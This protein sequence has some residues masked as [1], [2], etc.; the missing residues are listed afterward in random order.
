MA[1]DTS[2]TLGINRSTFSLGRSL[3]RLSALGLILVAA[4]AGA[5]AQDCNNNGIDD[6]CDLDCGSPGGGCDVP[7]C[8]LA[9][10]CDGN[11]VPDSCDLADFADGCSFTEVLDSNG[12]TASDATFTGPPDDVYFGLGGQQVTYRFDCGFIYDGPGGDLN[13]YEVDFGSAEFGAV[14]VLVS[15]DG[16]NFTSIR[17]SAHAAAVIPGDELHGSTNFARSYDIG[18]AGLSTVRYVRLDGNG[19]GPSGTS[20]GFD[21]DA[22]GV[23]HRLGLDCDSSGTLDSCEPL[24]DCDADGAPDACTVSLGAALD[25][26]TNGIPDQCDAGGTSNDCDG[27][28]VPDEC[29]ADCDL[30]GTPD[31]CDTAGGV[32]DCNANIRPDSCDLASAGPGYAE[33]SPEFQPYGGN[34][35]QSWT[36]P[37]AFAANG[38]VTL[39]VRALSDL[40]ATTEYVEIELNGV[41]LGRLFEGGGNNCSESVANLIIDADTFNS[42]VAGGD[43]V[44]QFTSPSAVNRG[45]CGSSRIQADLSYEAIVDCNSNG[46]VDGCDIAAGADDVNLNGLPDECEPDCNGNGTPDDYDVSQGISPDCNGNGLPDSCD[47][48]AATSDDCDLDGTPDECQPDCNGNGVADVCDISGGTSDDCDGNSVPDSCELDAQ[49][50]ACDFGSIVIENSTGGDDAAFLGAP[51]GDFWGIG[52]QI[53]T[54]E[55]TCGW[56]VDGPGADLTLY[57][58]SSGGQEFDQVQLLVSDDGVNYVDISG[59]ARAGQRIPGDQA[60]GGIAFRRSYDLAGSGLD[61]VRFVRINGSGSGSGGSSS[62]FDLDAVGAIHLLRGDCDGSGTLDVCE[63]LAD[64]DA[65]G[66]PDACEVTLIEGEDCNANAVPDSCD[67]GG[68]SSDCDLNGVPDECQP[69]CDGNSVADSCDLT[70]GATDCN[71]NGRPDSCDLTQSPVLE[72]SADLAPTGDAFPQSFTLQG[73]PPASAAVAVRVT[74]L[75]DLASTGEYYDIEL[76]GTVVGRVFDSGGQDCVQVESIFNVDAELY[77]G[78]VAGTDATFTAA[79]QG[80]DPWLCAG[81]F[82]RIE[83]DYLPVLDC[84]GNTQLDRCDISGGADD[85]E[86]DGIPDTCEPDCDGNGVNDECD[87][88]DF[89]VPDCNDNEVPDSCDLA[90][91]TSDDCDADGV[92]DECPTCPPVEVVYIMDTSSSMN[93]EGAALCDSIAAIDA[94][95][96]AEL[97][98]I[99]S[100]ALG[101]TEAGTGVFNCLTDS[102]ANRYG[103]AVPG[104][105][106]ANNTVL[107]SCPGGNEV[108]IEDWGRAVSVVAGTKAWGADSVRVVIPI[109]DEGPWCGDPVTDPGVDRDSINHASRVSVDNAVIVSPITGSGSSGAVIGMAQDL[110]S[111]TGGVAQESTVP[112]QD[113]ADAIKQQILDACASF[114]DCNGNARPDSCDLLDGLSDDC[115]LNDQPDE[116]QPDCNVNGIADPCDI[117]AGTSLDDNANTV[118]DECERV[119]LTLAALDLEW[120]EI[121]GA[122]GYDVIRGD[123]DG[124]LSTGGNFS[125]SVESCL[126]NDT[127]NRTWPHGADPLPGAAWFYLVR[128]ELASGAL[129]YDVIGGQVAPRDASIEASPN[130][131]P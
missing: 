111:A 14:D 5:W 85:C 104:D 126:A 10:D 62:G 6:A 120:T 59:A 121:V 113:L 96:Q 110:A 53:V 30:S 77:N 92:P 61:A 44:F 67:L 83:L 130:A 55:W 73:P 15:A 31:T 4:T 64:C 36:V 91:A 87:I 56:I 25:C 47:I 122:L 48:A 41:P 70:S 22:I 8:G 109:S 97:G 29:Q 3:L 105:P 28:S 16:V 52:G 124:L 69:D 17:E 45:E 63:P 2:N 11:G 102:V 51:D 114:S 72:G 117:S 26:N 7:G 38:S 119:V 129:T 66:F 27:D 131:C 32:D 33:T 50:A 108:G 88:R 127:V 65:D 37:A 79:A 71:G 12:T 115:D 23:I 46:T 1:R 34:A 39:T 123:L 94:E 125:T 106:P 42:A 54:W 86:P 82:V 95:L 103:T 84:D 49:G 60:H 9:A 101:I 68:T 18:Y 75:A 19:T 43:A 24:A 89:I 128:G 112:D 20:S 98:A 21:L 40:D 35:S 76:N 81:S 107:G 57:E 80:V 13:V 99:Q 90:A 116:C 118:P 78:L 58:V 93:D 100:E 74:A